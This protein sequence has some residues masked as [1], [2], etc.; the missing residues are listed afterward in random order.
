MEVKDSKIKLLISYVFSNVKPPLLIS[1]NKLKYP[2]K[3]TSPYFTNL[4]H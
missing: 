1:D 4:F 2:H 3:I